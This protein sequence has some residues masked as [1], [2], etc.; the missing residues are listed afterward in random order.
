MKSLLKILPIVL[1]TVSIHSQ[2]LDTLINKT[3]QDFLLHDTVYVTKTETT[4][5]TKPETVIT[6][7]GDIKK[8]DTSLVKTV[9]PILKSPKTQ[10]NGNFLT[11]LKIVGQITFWT[12]LEII[13]II[14]AGLFTN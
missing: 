6:K 12:I 13:F 4:F 10:V 1:L 3:V 7:T 8:K 11:Q 9:T 5:V 2:V 14:L